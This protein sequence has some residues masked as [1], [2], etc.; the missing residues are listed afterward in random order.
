MQNLVNPGDQPKED[1]G[2]NG[3]QAPAQKEEEN[4]EVLSE[5]EEESSLEEYE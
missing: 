4:V 2:R 5:F 1:A 3:A